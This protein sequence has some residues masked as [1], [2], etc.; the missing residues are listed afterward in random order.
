MYI[1]WPPILREK[2]QD[3]L[4]LAWTNKFPLI[5]EI[6]PAALV[7]RI[8]PEILGSRISDYVYVDFASGAGGPTPYIEKSL[9]AQLSRAG[10]RNVDF[11]LSDISPHISA[12][13]AASKKSEHLSYVPDSVDATNA[14]SAKILL[15]NVASTKEKKV[16]RLFSL[17]FH[18]FDDDMAA[19][20]LQN[21][22]ETADGFW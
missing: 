4:T 17:A 2:V 13:S 12:W 9:N 18:H 14:P 11:V 22:V 6:S 10:K 8:L 16:M 15:Q 5:Q 1:R 21:T 19:R 3:A 20:V 7:A